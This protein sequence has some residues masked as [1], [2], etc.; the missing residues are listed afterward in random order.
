MDFARIDPRRDAEAGATW[1]VDYEGEE[2]YH[3]GKPIE[4]DF[5]G[6]ESA[7]AKRAAAKMARNAD[8]R[9]GGKKRNLRNMT[10]EQIID[11]TEASEE[12]Q[13][14][15]FAAITTGWRNVVYLEDSE[16]DNPKAKPEPLPFSQENAVK[17]FRTRPWIMAG[18]DRFLGEKAN[19]DRS[20]K[21]S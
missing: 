11:A 15:F 3:E 18:A 6:L 12:E 4:I 19:F 2:L 5:L 17:L 1:H 8:R 20:K 13:A 16:I 21:A 14:A 10:V 9:M 7:A